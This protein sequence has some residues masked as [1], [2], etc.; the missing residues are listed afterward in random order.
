MF[1]VKPNVPILFRASFL[2]NFIDQNIIEL[3]NFSLLEMVKE[4]KVLFLK[5]FKVFQKTKM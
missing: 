4:G 5:D 2:F 3:S 1:F